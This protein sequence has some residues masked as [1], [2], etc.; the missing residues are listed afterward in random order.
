[1][2][3]GVANIARRWIRRAALPLAAWLQACA[4]GLAATADTG[5]QPEGLDAL[6]PALMAKHHVPGVAIAGIADRRLAWHRQYGVRRASSSDAVT[7]ETL[8][9]AASMSKPV[10][11]YVAL[12][13]VESGKLDLDRPLHEYLRRPYVPDQ[14]LH[15]KITAR[16]TLA[17]RTGFPNWRK[18]GWRAGGPLPV[19]FEP[20]TRFG[21]S[22]EGYTYL[23]R[24]IEH[25]TGEP[26]E[27]Y[28]TRTL[29]APLGITTGGFSWQDR[30]AAIAAAGHDAKGE[31]PP[32]RELFRE[33]N[34]AY[35]FYC[36]PVEYARFIIEMLRVDRSAPHSL[37][38]VSIAAMLTPTSE[39]TGPKPLVRQDGSRPSSS[40]YGLGWAIDLTARGPRVRHSGSNGT[41]FRCYCEFYPERGTGLVIMTNAAG[42]A[43]LWREVI[44]QVGEP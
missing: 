7:P 20:G 6:V 33:A 12:K 31:V 36:S 23:Q 1:M 9:E 2:F 22:G 25:I 4:P 3:S 19:N 30:F 44:E 43:A 15:L 35:S 5:P 32:S 11:A 13:L 8:F 26:F 38:A 18:G 41:G 28:L 29:L 14:P 39:T 10:G 24:V 16:M 21:Y 37:S 17:H 42:G 34:T 40:H 27:P